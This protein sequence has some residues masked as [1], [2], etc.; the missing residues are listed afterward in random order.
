[1]AFFQGVT[2][3]RSIVG[4][5]MLCR[6]DDYISGSSN[7]AFGGIPPFRHRTREAVFRCCGAS[8]HNRAHAFGREKK[9]RGGA[10]VRFFQNHTAI[11]LMERIWAKPYR[12]SALGEGTEKPSPEGEGGRRSLTDEAKAPHRLF[13]KIIPLLCFWSKFGLAKSRPIGRNTRDGRTSNARP[14]KRWGRVSL[15]CLPCVKVAKRH[16]RIE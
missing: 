16:E 3:I 7:I 8:P 1:M 10:P 9:G 14:Y 2:E 5:A 13:A 4:K 12:Y 15:P 11:P 6:G